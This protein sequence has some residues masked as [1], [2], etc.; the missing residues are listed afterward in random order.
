MNDLGGSRDGDGQSSAAD[1]VVQEI[2]K[3]GGKAIA[4]YSMCHLRIFLFLV[5][6]FLH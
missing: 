2:Q 4:D 1:N 3:I 6:N 5:F